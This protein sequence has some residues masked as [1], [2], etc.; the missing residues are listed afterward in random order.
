M[1]IDLANYEVKAREAVKQ[2][3]S[4]RSNAQQKQKVSG[5]ADQGQRGSV[6]GGKNM[7]GFLALMIDVIRANGLPDADLHV[8]QKVLTLPGYFRPTKLW[9]LLV[10]NEGQL[11]A[12]L[13]FK[14]HV[15]SFGNNFNNRCEEAI[16][17]AHD[18]A[19]AYREGAFG[20]CASPFVGWMILVED[21]PKSRM[22]VK[23]KAPH[24]PVLEGFEHASYADRYDILCR[25]LT[26][27]KLYTTA[28]VIMSPRSAASDGEY[29]ELSD[30]TG[31]R[32]FVAE[33]AGHI[34]TENAKMAGGAG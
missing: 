21:A 11:V 18:L 13:E 29:S 25:K 20:D 6:T 8:Q 14:S 17:T 27:E 32:T 16:G 23:C 28:S 9:D 22:P 33:L 24:F 7:D 10:M 12:A 2:F 31:L 4:G 1:T 3:W 5:K 34:A 26:L 30:L 15:G 19:T